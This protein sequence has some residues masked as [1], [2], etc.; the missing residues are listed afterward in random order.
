MT[1]EYVKTQCINCDKCIF[2]RDGGHHFGWN[3]NVNILFV[4]DIEYIKKI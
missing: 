2:E 1:Q 4:S 3:F